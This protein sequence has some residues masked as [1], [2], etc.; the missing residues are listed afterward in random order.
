MCTERERLQ[1]IINDRAD[2]YCLGEDEDSDNV[3]LRLEL[4]QS[5]AREMALREALSDIVALDAADSTGQRSINLYD[6]RC[7]AVKALD[8]PATGWP[9]SV[10]ALVKDT[11]ALIDRIDQG[12]A[13]GDRLDV[14]PVRR[15]LVPFEGVL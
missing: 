7:E 5:Q 10:T 8:S 11:T 9:E 14:E 15:D 12:L 6:A 3:A 2:A 4:A 1:K 13:L